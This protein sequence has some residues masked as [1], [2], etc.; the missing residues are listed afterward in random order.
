[1]YVLQGGPPSVSSPRVVSFASEVST[2]PTLSTTDDGKGGAR[3]TTLTTVGSTVAGSEDLTAVSKD[4]LS[5]STCD[6]VRHD[7]MYVT[8]CVRCVIIYT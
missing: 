6:E 5:V 2:I 3:L 7:T 1:M 4:F 8:M